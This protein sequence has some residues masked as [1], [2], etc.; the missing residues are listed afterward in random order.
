MKSRK[1]DFI[2]GWKNKISRITTQ[3]EPSDFMIKFSL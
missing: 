1:K 2:D 3:D